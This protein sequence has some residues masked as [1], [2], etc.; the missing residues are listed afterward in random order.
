MEYHHINTS[1]LQGQFYSTPASTF[2]VENL[3][4]NTENLSVMPMEPDLSQ[5]TFPPELLIKI[6]AWEFVVKIIMY[7]VVIVIALL[8]NSLII[9][10]VWRNKRMRTTTNYYI[11][12]L[13]VSDLLITCSCTW[14]NLV[15]DLTHGW[16]LGQFFCKFN[17]FSQGKF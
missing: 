6:P 9:I 11:V 16:V 13:A 14:V 8:G 1:L 17:S 4:R 15:D 12:N 5:H 3:T 2:A 7:T 10:I